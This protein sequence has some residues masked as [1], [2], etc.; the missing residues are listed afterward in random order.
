MKHLYE[1]KKKLSM[2]LFL[3][4]LVLCLVF[5]FIN[6][7]LGPQNKIIDPNSGQFAVDFTDCPATAPNTCWVAI[8]STVFKTDPNRA[9]AAKGLTAEAWVKLKS[10]STSAAIFGRM[11]SSGIMLY[12]KNGVPK[13]A[14]RRVIG[15]AG[16][17]STVDLI[18]E[19][20]SAFQA[21]IWTHI[22]AVLSFPTSATS[23]LDL[24]VNGQLAASTPAAV[25]QQD[26]TEPGGTVMAVGTFLDAFSIDGVSQSLL[27][28]IVDEPRLWGESRTP[29]AIN[30]CMDRELSLD[31]GICGRMNKNLI[32]YWRFNEGKG[33]TVNEW[34]GLGA[35]VKERNNPT[36][37]PG[38][39][40][41]SWISG[42]TED[43]PSLTRTD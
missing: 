1:I 12:V 19:A 23:T 11:D 9:M 7:G 8:D 6:C 38:H 28:A 30:K 32:G 40:T 36:P 16:S 20:P 25:A 13:A 31:D 22:A 34:T 29:N 14:V 27:Q 4:V 41:L 37:S 17:T 24:Y 10:T 18:T 2:L 33:D 21:N 43:A 5:I 39:E 26:Y 3:C 15:G 42:W 35:G